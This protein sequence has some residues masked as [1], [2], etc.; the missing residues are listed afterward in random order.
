MTQS[1]K[2]RLIKDGTQYQD[3]VSCDL[4]SLFTNKNLIERTEICE[5][6]IMYTVRKKSYKNLL[7]K[8]NQ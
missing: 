3:N 1:K 5:K 7:V 4:R 6:K 8:G 2:Y